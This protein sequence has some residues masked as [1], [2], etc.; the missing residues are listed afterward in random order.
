MPLIAIDTETGGFDPATNALLSLTAVELDADLQPGRMLS[1]FIEP[2]PGQAISPEAAR[3]NGYSPEAWK[4][5]DAV[6]LG[7]AMAAL[8]SWLPRDAEA[9]AH[10]AP[11]DKAFVDAAA[12]RT[13]RRIWLHPRWRCSCMTMLAVNDALRCNWPNAKLDTLGLLCGFWKDG[14]R[15]TH[16]AEADALA[17]AAGYRW[18]LQLI[19]KGSQPVTAAAGAAP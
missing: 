6:T 18:L 7:Q 16:A 14:E 5:R 3:I 8:A 11:F 17:C 1:L 12:A 13:K 2:E 9:L 19:R 4:E 10:N 15:G